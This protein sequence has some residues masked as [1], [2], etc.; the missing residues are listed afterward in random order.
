MH[1]GAECMFYDAEG[2]LE[3]TETSLCP[4]G[5]KHLIL[6]SS[7]RV[8][9]EEVGFSH[10]FVYHLEDE[11]VGE[12]GH[13]LRSPVS[14]RSRGSFCPSYCCNIDAVSVSSHW[15]GKEITNFVVSR[16]SGRRHVKK[17]WCLMH[18]C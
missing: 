7:H 4:A 1:V 10:G 3:R 8:K 9:A 6:Q 13:G 5:K 14:W 12:D 11:V 15:N 17:I 16:L 18:A 2:V